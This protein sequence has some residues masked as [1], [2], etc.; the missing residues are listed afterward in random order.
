VKQ[1]V[2]TAVAI[3]VGLITLLGYFIE[4]VVPGFNIH[5]LFIR[6]AATLAAVAFILGI[7]NLMGVH[8]GRVV[9]QK[10]DWFQSLFLILSAILVILIGLYEVVVTRKGPGGPAMS[11]IFRS[12][13][14]PL[15]AAAASLLV[16]FLAVA[17][18][19]SL[20]KR[21]NI[22]SVLFV[23]TIIV[24]LICTIPMTAGLNQSLANVR[25]WVVNVF[26]TAGVRGM[27]LG[28]A[29]GTIAAGLRVLTGIDQ[30]HSEREP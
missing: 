23:V 16:F 10:R 13:L 28:V 4:P 6:W 29:L 25:N 24:V 20:R 19:R 26:A 27:L 15:E 9:Y 1:K 14:A 18:F 30:P 7:V 3:L 21:P 2:P 12:I 8:I 22:Y 11:W 17:A 5:R